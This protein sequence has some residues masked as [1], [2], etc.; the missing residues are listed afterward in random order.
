MG[1]AL[2]CCKKDGGAVET[3]G[4]NPRTCV[5]VPNETSL[6]VPVSGRK[7][8]EDTLQSLTSPMSEESFR[9]HCENSEFAASQQKKKYF[10]E[11]A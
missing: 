7:R 5:P 3:A 4:V 10:E 11:T 8:T 1:K 6:V 9:L 2:L